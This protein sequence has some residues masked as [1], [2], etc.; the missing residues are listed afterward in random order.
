MLVKIEARILIFP[1]TDFFSMHVRASRHV[2]RLCMSSR[3]IWLLKLILLLFWV[4]WGP[5]YPKM[6]GGGKFIVP[7]ALDPSLYLALRAREIRQRRV[8]CRRAIGVS[9][10]KSCLLA[11]PRLPAGVRALGA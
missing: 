2:F 8:L 10:E 5:I 4:E 3:R 1:G 6:W 9:A 11:R 7:T